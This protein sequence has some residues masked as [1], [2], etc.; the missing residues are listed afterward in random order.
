MTLQNLFDIITGEDMGGS[1]SETTMG[2][3]SGVT[4]GAGT[5]ID[6]SAAAPGVYEF[7]YTIPATAA[8]PAVS[9]TATITVTNQQLAGADNS[10]EFCEGSGAN[11]SL[12][13][14]LSG[15]DAGGTW[16]QTGGNAV[17]IS[18]PSSVDFSAAAPGTYTF[19]YTHA[20]TGSCLQSQATF[21]ITITDQL[22]AGADNSDEFCEGEGANYDLT[23]LLSGAD[24]GG[25]WSQASGIMIDVSDPANV[26]FSGAAPGMYIFCYMQVASGSCPQDQATFTITIEDRLDAGMNGTLSICAGDIFTEADLFASLGGSPDPGGVWTPMLAGA[27]TYTYTHAA[28]A[29]CTASS[30]QV[31]V[32]ETVGLDPGTNGTLTI[33]VGETVTEAQLFNALGGMPDAGGNWTPAFAGAG[34]YTYTHPAVG[35]C[36]ETSAQVVVTEEMPATA[37][38]NGTRELCEGETTLQNLFSIITG[39][40]MGGSWSE[41]TVGPSS[42]VTIGAGTAVDFSGAAPGVYEFTYTIAATA[43]CPAV[44]STATITV[45]ERLEAGADNSGEICE[46]EGANYNLASLLSGADAGGAWT[47]TG[48]ATVNISNPASVDFSSAAPGVY[49]FIYAQAANGACPQDQATLTLIIQDRLDAGENGALAICPGEMV[50]V[51]QLFAAL[52]GTPDPGGVWTPALAGVGTY[53][54]THPAVGVCTASSAEV[55]VT[56]IPVPTI[57]VVATDPTDCEIF[58]GRIEINATGSDLK[59]SIN[60]G[61]SFVDNGVFIGLGPGSY[62]IVVMYGDCMEDAGTVTLSVPPNPTVTNVSVNNPDDCDSPTGSITITSSTSVINTEYSIDG[63][64]TWQ[65]SNIFN[66]LIAGF[67][68]VFV[69]NS[70]GT[71]PTAGPVVVLQ[72]PDDPILLSVSLND[73]TECDGGNGTIR[74]VGGGGEPPYQFRLTGPNGLVL[75]WTP[76]STEFT[77]TGLSEGDYKI[78]IRNGNGTCEVDPLNVRLDDIDRPTIVGLRTERA[79][80]LTGGSATLFVDGGETLGSYQYSTDALTWTAGGGSFT[81]TDL[82]P[83]VHT[84]YVAN[85]DLS[86]PVSIDVMIENACLELEKS[87]QL[88]DT[89]NDGFIGVGDV[90]TFSFVVTNTGTVPIANVN[91]SDP[92]LSILSSFAGTLNPG[93]SYFGASAMY[94]VTAADVAAGE[95]V[96]QA[97]ASGQDPDNML[98]EDLSDDPDDLTDI[99]LEGDGEPDDPTVTPIPMNATFAV[100][101]INQT[102]ANVPV[103]GDVSTNDFDLEGDNQMVTSALVDTDGDGMVDDN[104]VIGNNTTLYGTDDNGNTVVA[105][106]VTLNADGTYTYLPAMGFTGKV[107]FAYTVT[108]DNAIS[109][110]MDDATV[111]IRVIGESTPGINGPPVA[112]DDTRTTEQGLRV[113]GNVLDNDSDP[114]GDPITV[115]SL[116]ADT[117]GDGML[118][119]PLMLSTTTDIYGTDVNGNTVLTGELTLNP[120]GTFDF[121]PEPSFLGKVPVV[122][123]ISDPDGLTDDAVLTILI[124]A[125]RGNATYANDDANLSVQGVPQTGNVLDND[126]DPQDD[127]QTVTGATASD[128]TALVVDGITPNTLPSG[129]T[130]VIAADG[131]YTYAPDAGFVGT[132]IVVYA[133]EDDGVPTATDMATLYLTT[134]CLKLSAGADNSDEFCE[135]EGANYDLTALLDATADAGGVWAQTAGNMVDIANP[136]DVDFS[137]AAPGVYTFTYTHTANAACTQDQATFTI[138]VQD[139]LSAGADNSMEFC[140]GTN[141]AYDLTALLSNDADPNGIWAQASGDPIDIT[142]ETSVDFSMAAVGVYTFTYTHLAGVVCPEDQAT[143]T[144]TIVSAPDINLTVSDDLV[145]EGGTATITISASESGVSY[146]LRLDS[147]D[148]NVGTAIASTGGTISFNVSPSSTTTYNVLATNVTT[149]C[150]AELIDKPTVTTATCNTFAINDINQTPVNVSVSG[151]VLTND[152]DRQGDMQTV[153][154]ALADTD[155]DGLAGE[156]LPLGMSTT[157]YGT[158][159]NGSTVIAG[160]LLLFSNG[161][162][163]FTPAMDFTGNV[164]FRYTIT[165]DNP[166]GFSTDAAT[167][168]IEVIGESDPNNNEPPVAND[169]TQTTEQ[170]TDVSGNVLDNDSDPDGDPITVVSALADTDGDGQV[171]DILPVGTPTTLYGTDQ[172]G[173]M[174]IAGVLTLNA[175]GVYT[176]DPEPSFLGEVPASYTIGDPDGLTDDATLTILVEGD[177]GNE[178]YANDDANVGP[179]DVGQAGNV[180]DND[181]DPENDLQIVTGATDGSGGAITVGTAANLP[182]GGTLT[183]NS[184]GS[185]LYEPAV[186]FVGTEIVVYTIEDGGTPTATD[187]ATLYLTTLPKPCVEIE[188]WVYLEGAAIDAAGSPTYSFPMRTDLNDLRLLPGQVLVDPFLGS[189]Y[190]PGQPYSDTPW[191]YFGMEGALYDSGGDSNLADAGYPATVVDWVLVSLRET[192]NATGSPLC[193]AAAL[194]HDDGRIELTSNFECCTLDDAQ[195][196]YLVV[197]HRSHLIVMSDMP[198]PIVNGKLTYDFRNQQS[199]IDDPFGFGSFAGQKEVSTGVFVMYGGNGDQA[200]TSVSDTD[201]NSDDRARFELDNSELGEYRI[202]DYNLSGD[203]NFADRLIFEQN[204]GTFTSVPRD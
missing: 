31:I 113:S 136:A 140:E 155:G 45:T 175:N 13:A 124:E 145:C 62:A 30:A 105:G 181:S 190:N 76:A 51:A 196:Y 103:S 127:T 5:A 46:G 50:T 99:D 139:R 154:S 115:I 67:Y 120:D 14:L 162:Y 161:G 56:E 15:A 97:T 138:T 169:D 180:L 122:Y 199:Y 158:D 125:D 23:A 98:V 22:L 7:T 192:P 141:L 32:S 83:G 142:D 57:D 21:T 114:D 77:F 106:T 42:G 79:M 195:S 171:D 163:D 184:N 9:A 118:D 63:G 73:P 66:G 110:A 60:G 193:Q 152:F 17:N 147:D 188:A 54:Y 37:G 1:W 27:G 78:A 131:S 200:S 112:N 6:F 19:T 72:E 203:T 143:F 16:A 48:G 123:T 52:G 90:I 95:Y 150:S 70:D 172:T 166:A 165:D 65:M 146:Q 4:V 82:G 84:L 194:L 43:A 8:C 102:P 33:C 39:E 137:A 178:T 93:D 18:N 189:K 81:F 87:S 61:L 168:A 149:A 129:G 38:N 53:T 35:A 11:Y 28:T 47:Q 111:S 108:D 3:S 144:I 26:D 74:A 24:A 25:I 58:N 148:S 170:D 12:T 116:L 204:N 130:L 134:I 126:T 55:V 151:N 121:D 104:L 132:E 182:S 91:I 96:N 179:Q 80:C 85:D 186:G 41:T 156:N 164:P 92:Q 133:I 36:E 49:T 34:T 75:G 69:R 101:D 183:L 177:V 94:T 174:V 159:D 2:P 176:F 187:M 197:E 100:N 128:N 107:P 153:T 68:E 29:N 59:Y 40:N 160:T 20:A 44:S 10:D 86:C 117:D 88:S 64:E 109:P 167:V 201:I 202:G 198:V 173:T 157:L 119:D 135:G 89:N 71:C 185:Y 191:S